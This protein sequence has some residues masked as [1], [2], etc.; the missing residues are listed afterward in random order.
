MEDQIEFLVLTQ[1]SS[2]DAICS[3]AGEEF[4]KAVVEPGAAVVLKPI[5][6]EGC[7]SFSPLAG[8]RLG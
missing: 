8:R 7:P 3:F 6:C 4:E 2:F 1:W 5:S